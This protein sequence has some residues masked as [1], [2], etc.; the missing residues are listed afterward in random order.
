MQ[1]TNKATT[2]LF[3]NLKIIASL[4]QHERIRSRG[5]ELL[6]V[7]RHGLLEG[8]QRWLAGESR[9]HNLNSV[10]TV[11]DSAFSYAHMLIGRAR[12]ANGDGP[13]DQED[14]VFMQRLE[15][16]L[17]AARVGCESLNCTY[18]ADTVARARIDCMMESID[19]HLEVLTRWTG[20]IHLGMF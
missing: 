17:R 15:R 1:H 16:E 12:N 9:E 8:L 11:L 13:L 7:S 10:Q 18:E 2:T 19:Q 4:R 3:C 20:D 6:D 14:V 5:G